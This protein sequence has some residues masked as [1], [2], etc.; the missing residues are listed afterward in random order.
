MLT[1]R[2]DGRYLVVRTIDGVKHYIYGRT[3]R[4]INT[5]L[6]EFNKKINKDRKITDKNGYTLAEWLDIWFVRYKVGNNKESTLNQTKGYIQKI[7][8]A[9]IGSIKL[10]DIKPVDV[11]AFLSTITKSMMKVHYYRA[12]HDALN[13]AYI[14]DYTEKN[15]SERIIAPKHIYKETK[16]FT[17]KDEHIFITYLSNKYPQWKLFYKLMLY[18]GMRPREVIELKVEDVNTELNIIS[19]KDSKTTAGKRNIPIFDPVKSDL[20]ECINSKKSKD[21]VCALKSYPD[22]FEKVVEECQLQGYKPYSCRH[23][24]ATRCSELGISVKVL[25]HWL[26]HSNSRIT[27]K[28]YVHKLDDFEKS[29]VELLNNKRKI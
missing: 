27:L 11:E 19:I 9:P 7:K 8:A 21:N 16:A 5:K 15:I 24:F 18:E 1:K 23:T 20:I 17:L 10:A 25:Q 12:L 26:G 14:N 4:E 22:V 29:Q 6:K 13:Q 3:Y 28:H 2:K